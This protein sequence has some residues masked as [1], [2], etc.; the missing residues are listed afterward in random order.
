MF[1]LFGSPVA[2]PSS[3]NK[4]PALGMTPVAPVPLGATPATFATEA[5]PCK[6][7]TVTG[8]VRDSASSS[9]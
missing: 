8:V 6:L 1:V 9:T 5:V 2:V 7:P 3:D 4:L